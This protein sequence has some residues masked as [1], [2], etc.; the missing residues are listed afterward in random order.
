[1]SVRTDR[2]TGDLICTLT[3]ASGADRRI[4]I[5]SVLGERV[6]SAHVVQGHGRIKTA[7]FPAGAYI[8][9]LEREGRVEA[10]IRVSVVR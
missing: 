2:A 6:A 9:V 8:A 7:T 1:M 5:Y 4:T 10:T 3:G